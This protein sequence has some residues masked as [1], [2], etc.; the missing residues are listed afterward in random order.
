M[1][2]IRR[3][4]LNTGFN[5]V[6]NDTAKAVESTISLEALGLIVNLTSYAETWE[7]SKT[8]VYKRYA[9][10]GE[11]SVNS[12]WKELV[13]HKYIIEGKYKDGKKWMYVYFVRIQP[14]TDDESESLKQELEKEV[15]KPVKWSLKLDKS[16][17]F[18]RLQNEVFKKE[19][20]Q[21]PTKDIQ[22]EL[23]QKEFKQKDFEEEVNESVPDS[24]RDE[25]IDSEKGKPYS[26]NQIRILTTKV[27]TFTSDIDRMTICEELEREGFYHIDEETFNAAFS[28]YLKMA[29]KKEKAGNT[30]F[31]PAKYFAIILLRFLQIHTEV[32]DIERL[33]AQLK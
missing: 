30:I 12:A 29:K 23:K 19:T 27:G 32:S 15:G 33:S 31:V 17:D 13:E 16:R 3:V 26:F 5:P 10:H 4:P 22:K 11:R 8:E 28:N 9:K 25:S 24:V 21:Q 20:S 18:F 1:A 2:Q 14:F 7:I 6:P